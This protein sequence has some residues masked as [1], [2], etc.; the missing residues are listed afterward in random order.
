MEKNRDSKIIAIIAL[1]IAVV[2]LS[3][4]FAAF[5]QQLTI[6]PKADVKADNSKF[7]VLFSNDQSQATTGSV[8]GI[9]AEEDEGKAAG[10]SAEIT[11]T[12]LTNTEAVFSKE[13]QTI[14]YKW[15]V[16]N[17]GELDAYLTKI[18]FDSAKPTC[19]AK[20]PGTTSSDLVEAA[21][22]NVSAKLK[23]HTKEF[24]ETKDI[25]EEL[26]L[27][28]NSVA[29]IELILTS[30]T[31]ATKVDGDYTVTFGDIKLDYSSKK[32]AGV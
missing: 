3:V 7:K 25:T 17:D 15:W 13:G 2:G 21:C 20:V 19:V 6:T 29:E 16:R 23:V 24:T 11:E 10:G 31:G 22:A 4:G 5:S 32:P 26:K 12:T 1:V 28:A 27:E 8:E 9:V 14:T 18:T 30:G